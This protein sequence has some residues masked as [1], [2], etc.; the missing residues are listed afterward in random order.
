MRPEFDYLVTAPA[1]ALQTSEFWRVSC[2]S[3]L[4]MGLGQLGVVLL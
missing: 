3:P 1:A 2:G 4:A